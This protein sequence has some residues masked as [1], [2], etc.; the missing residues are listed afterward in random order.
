MALEIHAG[1]IGLEQVHRRQARGS[2]AAGIAKRLDVQTRLPRLAVRVDT[3]A[4]AGTGPRAAV[5]S[6]GAYD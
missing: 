4:R 6:D 3:F 2:K 1:R 5:G